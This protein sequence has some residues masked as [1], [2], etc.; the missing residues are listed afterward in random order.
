MLHSK[1]FNA[2][3]HLMLYSK[4][5]PV[6]FLKHYGVKGMKWGV[7]R[8]PEEL[9]HYKKNVVEKENNV[10]KIVMNAIESGLISRTVNKEKQ[11]R[12]LKSNSHYK[13]GRSYIDGDINTAQKLINELSGTG[14]PVMTRNVE[15]KRKERVIA[16]EEIGVNIDPET[17]EETRTNKLMIHYS[18]TGAH[19]FARKDEKDGRKT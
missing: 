10:D 17:K 8:T 3:G 7:R 14:K 1:S 11:E 9:G 19:I 15:W 2:V 18:K 4:P 13:D 5:D 12:H 16:S 6:T